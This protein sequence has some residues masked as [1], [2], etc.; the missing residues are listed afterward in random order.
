MKYFYLII[1]T[2]FT[3]THIDDAASSAPL[4]EGL[5]A[6]LATA[7][8]V[9]KVHKPAAAGGGTPTHSDTGSHTGSYTG[10]FGGAS[11]II[12]NHKMYELKRAQIWMY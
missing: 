12:A 4:D 2:L 3:I 1:L 7:Q 8:G 11:T 5:A 6:A 10:S 9:K